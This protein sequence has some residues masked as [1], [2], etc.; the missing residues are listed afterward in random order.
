MR[1]VLNTL[2]PCWSLSRQVILSDTAGL[3]G[4]PIDAVEAEGVGRAAAAAAGAHVALIVLDAADAASAAR[5]ADISMANLRAARMSEA[6]AALMRLDASAL[7]ALRGA[8]RGSRGDADQPLVG[9]QRVASGRGTYGDRGFSDVSGGGPVPEVYLILNKSDLIDGDL[10]MDPIE[11]LSEDLPRE[12]HG[13][14]G[15]GATRRRFDWRAARAARAC[16]NAAASV[17]VDAGLPLRNPPATASTAASSSVDVFSTL[18]PPPPPPLYAAGGPTEK[19]SAPFP[20]LKLFTA[21]GAPPPGWLL[22][23]RTGAGVEAFVAGLT[24]V[25]K[26][27]CAPPLPKNAAPGGRGDGAARGGGDGGRGDEDVGRGGGGG[28]EATHAWLITRARHRAALR[29]AEAALSRA[30][31]GLRAAAAAA[32]T[33]EAANA[34]PS[35]TPPP[36]P[37]AECIAE[38]LRAARA[39]LGRLAGTVDCEE[40]LGAIFADFCIGK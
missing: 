18:P 21:P 5:A 15:E 8:S 31:E 20:A 33:S 35:G 10:R 2:S 26:A 19:G 14:R 37:S 9:G 3:R 25:V 28:D 7:T 13:E 29:E 11:D 40:V 32:T 1:R 12:A 30:E 39:A 34:A 17:L 4:G 23:C 16:L 36:P 6:M 22:S 27:R 38:D 24:A